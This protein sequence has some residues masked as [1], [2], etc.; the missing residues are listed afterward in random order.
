[1]TTSDKL[2]EIA[3]KHGISAV[4]CSWIELSPIEQQKLLSDLTALISE[5]YVEK[6][7]Y[8]QLREDNK[9]L[10]EYLNAVTRENNPFPDRPNPRDVNPYDSKAIKRSRKR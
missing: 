4:N 5:G 8:D 1:M 9:K 6:E 7:K 3:E 2:R 10:H